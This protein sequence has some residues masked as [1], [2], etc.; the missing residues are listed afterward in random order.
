MSRHHRYELRR[1]AVERAIDRGVERFG[2]LH[3]LAEKLVYDR[4]LLG[5]VRNG[6]RGV[7][8]AVIDALEGAGLLKPGDADGDGQVDEVDRLQS[9]IEADRVVNQLLRRERPLV[10]VA[11]LKGLCDLMERQYSSP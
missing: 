5:K 2:T 7:S 10:A 1:V 11:Q 8:A 4:T 3:K 6:E 9:A